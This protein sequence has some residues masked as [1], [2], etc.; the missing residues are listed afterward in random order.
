MRYA[1][2]K[3]LEMNAP[4]NN[5]LPTLTN[6]VIVNLR[7]P[8]SERQAAARRQVYFRIIICLTKKG[9]NS[10][11]KNKTFCF[12]NKEYIQL[13]YKKE[14]CKK[15]EYFKNNNAGNFSFNRDFAGTAKNQLPVGF[16]KY[17]WGYCI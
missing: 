9:L 13:Y 10:L 8:D 16:K 4:S 12:K 11:Q 17:E 15:Y 5:N 1:S 14:L 7:N 3:G 2:A 6:D